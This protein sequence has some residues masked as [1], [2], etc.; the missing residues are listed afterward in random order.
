MILQL[1]ERHLR[2]RNVE[3]ARVVGVNFVKQGIYLP[4]IVLPLLGR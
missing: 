4:R 1:L 3:E 2:L